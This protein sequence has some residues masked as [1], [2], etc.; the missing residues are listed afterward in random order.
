MI[1]T[2]QGS[3]EPPDDSEQRAK[4]AVEKW[5]KDKPEQVPYKHM[6]TVQF[7][8]KSVNV[9]DTELPRDIVNIRRA[10]EGKQL[11]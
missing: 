5:L 9:H 3:F 1:H 4:E 6:L 2:K 10:R 7:L 11:L 8:G